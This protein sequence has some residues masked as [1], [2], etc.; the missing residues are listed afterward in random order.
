M[1]TYILFSNFENLPKL[2]L[3]PYGMEIKLLD[4]INNLTRGVDILT[5]EQE[6]LFDWVAALCDIEAAIEDMSE[7]DGKIVS[8]GWYS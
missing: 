1:N 2:I 6:A 7:V 3:L 5:A 8:I 4:T